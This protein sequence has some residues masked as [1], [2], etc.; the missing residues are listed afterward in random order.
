MAKMLESVK[1]A[2]L[3]PVILKKT[4]PKAG[5][6]SKKEYVAMNKKV[7][8]AQIAAEKAYREKLAEITPKDDEVSKVEADVQKFEQMIAT[9]KTQLSELERELAESADSEKRPLKM[10]IGKVK[11]A[12]EDAEEK[13]AEAQ[14]NA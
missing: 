13:L 7:K 5:Q 11:R 6:M 10:Q 12:I 1:K 2:E 3:P 9:R 8:E 4:N 14:K